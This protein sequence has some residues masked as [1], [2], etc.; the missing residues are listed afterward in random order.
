MSWLWPPE[1]DSPAARRYWYAA[2]VR[3]GRPTHETVLAGR[4]EATADDY[5]EALAFLLAERSPA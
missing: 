5:Y 1:H 4:A 2:E 3:A